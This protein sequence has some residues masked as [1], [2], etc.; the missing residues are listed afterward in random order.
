MPYE[1]WYTHRPDIVS[2]SEDNKEVG[3][4]A[5]NTIEFIVE[6]ITPE[7]SLCDEDYDYIE[8]KFIHSR[9]AES[10]SS[11]KLSPDIAKVYES[12][13]TL[14]HVT[15]LLRTIF[16]IVRIDVA[17]QMDAQMMTCD[18]YI[19][20]TDDNI[21]IT[22]RYIHSSEYMFDVIVSNNNGVLETLHFPLHESGIMSYD[23]N[24]PPPSTFLRHIQDIVNT[25]K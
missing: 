20:N 16:K 15:R 25:H 8:T 5:V 6:S 24:F 18:L 2:S 22:L 4:I 3:T 17:G 23:M 10:S 11:S 14:M 1:A 7:A 9:Y 19:A 21:T 12:A 13:R